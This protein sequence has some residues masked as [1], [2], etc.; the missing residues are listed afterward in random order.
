MN[1]QEIA[2]FF[3]NTPINEALVRDLAGGAFIAEQHN[4][5]F[6][7]GTGTGKSHAVIAVI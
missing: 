1:N 2:T 4:A 3:A 7:G 6:V 5:V